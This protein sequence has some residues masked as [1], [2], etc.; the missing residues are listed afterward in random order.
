MGGILVPGIFR[1]DW[2]FLEKI[3]W[4]FFTGFFIEKFL[5]KI[6]NNLVDFFCNAESFFLVTTVIASENFISRSSDR[7]AFTE[8]RVGKPVKSKSVKNAER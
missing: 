1:A 5:K 7:F 8:R 6:F 2:I 4:K 3:I